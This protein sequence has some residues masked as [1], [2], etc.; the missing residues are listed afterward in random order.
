[1]TAAAADAALGLMVLSAWLGAAGLLRLRQPLDRLHVAPFLTVACG[2][3]LLVAALCADGVSARTGKIAF[4][5]AANLLGGAVASHAL[6]R[7]VLVRRSGE[8]AGE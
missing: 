8:G 1:M 7:A 5:L 2:G 6:G 4:A 3:F